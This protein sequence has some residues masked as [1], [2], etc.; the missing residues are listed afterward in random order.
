MISNTI[1]ILFLDVDLE[2]YQNRNIS[3]SLEWPSPDAPIDGMYIWEY[4]V[5]N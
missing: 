1:P 5:Q 4:D 2:F 3:L